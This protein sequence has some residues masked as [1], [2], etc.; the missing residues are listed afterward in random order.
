MP[1][2]PRSTKKMKKPV[3]KRICLKLSGEALEGKQG[4]GIDPKVVESI[5]GQIREVHDIGVDIMLVIGGGNFFRGV[6]GERNGIDRATGDHIGMLATVMN[7]LV[8]SN[9]LEK[10][11]IHT[12][13][14]SAIEIRALCEPYIR[15]RALRHL[16]KGRVVIFVAG[17]GNPFFTTDTAAALRAIEMNAGAILK[18]TKVDGVYDKDPR[19]HKDARMYRSL[20]YLD[21]I[22]QRLQVMDTTATSLCMENKLPIVVFN[23]TRVGNIRKVVTGEKI[24]TL[25]A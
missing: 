23:M 8:L 2:A 1:C 4:F 21:V 20:T 3:Y 11:G 17:T 6:E 22:K 12:R 9:A 16:G 5:A 13:V 7:G 24:G 15:R 19:K 14:Q 10:I 25:V 18:A